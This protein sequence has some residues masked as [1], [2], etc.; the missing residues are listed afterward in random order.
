VINISNAL[1]DSIVK[2]TSVNSFISKINS[3]HFCGFC[4]DCAVLLYYLIY[5]FVWAHVNAGFVHGFLVTPYIS[6]FHVLF[7]FLF[8][9]FLFVFCDIVYLINLM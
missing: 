5:F 3:L 8:S 6:C 9:N 1:L 4:A 7:M 2:S